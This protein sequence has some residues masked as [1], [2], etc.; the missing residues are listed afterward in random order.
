MQKHFLNVIDDQKRD[1]RIRPFIG[2]SLKLPTPW[3]NFHGKPPVKSKTLQVVFIPLPPL[4]PSGL[5]ESFADLNQSLIHIC[6]HCW[7]H[8]ATCELPGQL[9]TS[10]ARRVKA[11]GDW[12]MR[13]RDVISNYI[14]IR[15]LKLQEVRQR[16][17]NI[18]KWK[19]PL[20]LMVNKSW[21]CFFISTD[22][23]DWQW[24]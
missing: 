4:S 10:K 17:I 20:G 21:Q 12:T 13:E 6:D 15:P 9:Q 22:L 5:I 2:H 23:N 16:W 24:E 19:S 3:W 18:N 1:H 14:L 7:L 11:H 8:I